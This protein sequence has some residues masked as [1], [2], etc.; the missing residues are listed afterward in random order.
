MKAKC[1]RHGTHGSHPE[2]PRGFWLFCFSS[3]IA[4]VLAAAVAHPCH[5][6]PLA[7]GDIFVQPFVGASFDGRSGA[8]LGA[9][10]TSQSNLLAGAWTSTA[11][12][13]CNASEGDISAAIDAR[14]AIHVCYYSFSRGVKYATNKT[15]AW[16]A[17]YLYRDDANTYAEPYC[18]LVVDGNRKDHVVY[19]VRSR[20]L[21]GV[22]TLYYA[23]NASGSWRNT[24]IAQTNDNSAFG[25]SGIEVT[26]NGKVHIA[27]VAEMSLVYKTNVSGAWVSTVVDDWFQDAGEL[28]LASDS[29]GNV[30]MA[31]DDAWEGTLRLQEISAAGGLVSNIV[32]DGDPEEPT[33]SIGW[34]PSIVIDKASNAKHITYWDFEHK[35][36]KLYSSGAISTIG[37][38]SWPKAGI[39]LDRNGKVYVSFTDPDS[40]NPR[41]KY[42]TN[43]SGSWVLTDL[44]PYS[45]AQSSDVVVGSRGK[46]SVIYSV[47]NNSSLR[48]ISR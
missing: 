38:C 23:T 17:R 22:N 34:S 37:S 16:V 40:S 35:L 21:D 45:T 7:D 47:R 1:A 11:I 19:A 30:F 44:P 6:H 14:N 10:E 15:G 39:A 13:R 28:S 41:L 9:H 27:F 43:K 24:I 33:S 20:F 42:A 29:S 12:D 8:E 32:L 18:K 2:C 48:I 36:L 25:S 4:L 3:V 26:T 5:A 46:V 31:Y